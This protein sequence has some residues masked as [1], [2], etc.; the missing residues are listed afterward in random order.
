MILSITVYFRDRESIE[1]RFKTD[2]LNSYKDVLFYDFQPGRSERFP[3]KG[4]ET[5]EDWKIAKIDNEELFYISFEDEKAAEVCYVQSVED[6][7]SEVYENVWLY[8]NDIIC[9]KGS[10]I[11]VVEMIKE[12]VLS[13]SSTMS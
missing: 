2:L 1:S 7:G 4:F 3:V 11:S 13:Y 6:Y 10:S 9:Y 8:G 5:Y 12:M